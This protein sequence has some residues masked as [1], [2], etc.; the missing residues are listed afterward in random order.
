MGKN[1]LFMNDILWAHENGFRSS[2]SFFY[3]SRLALYAHS[4]KG[5]QL[6]L[7][8]TPDFARVISPPLYHHQHHY[9]ATSP[10]CSFHPGSGR[11]WLEGVDC[12]GHESN[13]FECI[14]DEWK[15]SSEYGWG[16]VSCF[17]SCDICYALRQA[18]D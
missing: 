5:V 8:T 18:R 17:M 12:K 13:L 2:R 9:R 16:K 4:A 10:S 14:T 11:I 3:A 6:P 7:K 15:D 1:C